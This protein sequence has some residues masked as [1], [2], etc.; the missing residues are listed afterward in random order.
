V[1]E[2]LNVNYQ[3]DNNVSSD[4][5]STILNG[6]NGSMTVIG[7]TAAEFGDVAGKKFSA[8]FTVTNGVIGGVTQ[9]GASD[10]NN[11]K[12]RGQKLRGQVLNIK[13]YKGE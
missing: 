6:F 1:A 7:Q 12:L 9:Y 4:N 3:Q 10:L 2:I 11:E 13:F 8:V 5:L